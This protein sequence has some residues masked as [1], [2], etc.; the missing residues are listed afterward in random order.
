[1]LLIGAAFMNTKF[2]KELNQNMNAKTR[3]HKSDSVKNAKRAHVN[4]RCEKAA[5]LLEKCPR[6]NNKSITHITFKGHIGLA[7]VKQLSTSRFDVV[8]FG[9]L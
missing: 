7:G 9:L 5:S 6:L 1:M 8:C 2:E 4:Q 3:F